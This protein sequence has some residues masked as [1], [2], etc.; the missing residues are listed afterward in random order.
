MLRIFCALLLCHHTDKHDFLFLKI[1][2]KAGGPN[3]F[4]SLIVI[5]CTMADRASG[6]ASSL[7]LSEFSDEM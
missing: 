2:R 5:D 3:Q 1:C 4:D 7:P 6:S